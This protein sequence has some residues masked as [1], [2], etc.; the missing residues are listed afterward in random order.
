MNS[1]VNLRLLSSIVLL[2]AFGAINAQL[3]CGEQLLRKQ[4]EKKYPK[5][6]DQ[7][8]ETFNKAVKQTPNRA[9]VY[10][11]PVVFHVVYNNDEENY[12]DEYIH[13]Q[14]A[15]LNEDFRR[16]NANAVDTRPV[17]EGVAA[18]AEIEFYLAQTDPDGNPTTGITRTFTD[19]T[20]FIELDI[21]LLLQAALACG[22]LGTDITEEQLAC[23]EEQ[24]GNLDIDLELVKQTSQG[25]ID[26]WDSD[27]YL[28]I[29]SCDLA[30][31][32]LGESTPFVL[33]FAYP[34]VGAPNWPAEI[35]PPKEFEGVVLHYKTVGRNHPNNGVLAGVN[36]AGRTGTHE[37]GHYLGLR[38]IWGDGDCSLDDGLSDTPGAA[39]NSQT[40]DPNDVSCAQAH[41]KDS[42]PEDSLPD[43]VENYMDYYIESCQNIFTNDQANL[44]RAMLEGPRADL[45]AGSS[46]VD[47]LDYTDV[48]ISPNP[49]IDLIN[50]NVDTND[51]L[52]FKILSLDGRLMSSGEVNNQIDVSHF[53]TG[54]YF[55]KIPSGKTELTFKFVKI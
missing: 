33:G 6:L 44:M 43:M 15:V 26:A 21:A 32:F 2:F 36:D 42:C 24:L 35:F 25:G 14:I 20:S 51:D 37:V 4:F 38:H 13:D 49:V 39:S 18:D 48:D 40:Q 1:T 54:I 9:N 29:W 8:E 7:I 12:P 5:F 46:S 45:V 3:V 47:E 23:L 11:I 53:N 55:I 50:I 30:V 28:N 17:F 27:H 34:P 31:D 52:R 19:R 41:D 10:Q 22:I 16:M